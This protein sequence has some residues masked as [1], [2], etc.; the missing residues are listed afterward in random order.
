MA[1]VLWLHKLSLKPLLL[2][3]L[4]MRGVDQDSL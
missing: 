2:A 3:C 4:D 1:C